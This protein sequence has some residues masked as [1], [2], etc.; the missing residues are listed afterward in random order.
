MPHEPN[1]EDEPTYRE[2]IIIVL[3]IAAFLGLLY[4]AAQSF[5]ELR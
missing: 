1:D 2:A 3:A 4:L 5:I